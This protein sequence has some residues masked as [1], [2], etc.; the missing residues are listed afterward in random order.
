MVLIVIF[1]MINTEE[2]SIDIEIGSQKRKT[3]TKLNKL[4]YYNSMKVQL[5][6]G[7]KGSN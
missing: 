4:P 3:T 5:A 7:Q 2:D 1:R 6:P